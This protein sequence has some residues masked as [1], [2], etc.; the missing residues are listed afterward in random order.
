[1]LRAAPVRP[2]SNK[3]SVHDGSEE[4]ATLK[5]GWFS[6]NGFATVDGKDVRLSRERFF[7]GAF[8]LEIDGVVLA[9]ARKPS[10][11]R[12][13]FEVEI[14][15]ARVH[16]DRESVISRSFV[17]RG[18]GETLGRIDPEFAFTRKARID[19]P[20]DWPTA[21]QLFVF[22][23]VLIIWKRMNHT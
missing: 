5:I 15:N 20:D 17:L 22:W 4:V 14:E 10:I 23:L 9:R 8:R 18:G 19:L 2:F 3:F 11:F 6:D 21:L 16:L 7:S 13:R 12:N 1:M